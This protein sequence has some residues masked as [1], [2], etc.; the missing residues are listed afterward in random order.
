MAIALKSSFAAILCFCCPN[1]V[2]LLT[3]L[4][5]KMKGQIREVS[6]NDIWGSGKGDERG[7]DILV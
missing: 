5:K 3:N 6:L 2:V 4:H 1:I 7:I